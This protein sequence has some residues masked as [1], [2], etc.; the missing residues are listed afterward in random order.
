MSARTSAER[1]STVLGRQLGDELRRLREAAGLSTTDAADVLDCTKGKVSRMEN[2]K[3][4]VRSPDVTALLNAY[5]VH[6][7]K[8]HRKLTNLARAA[9]HRRQHGWW[10]RYG[11]VLADTYRDYVTL[12]AVAESVRTFQAQLV[13]GLL[14]TEKYVRAVTVASRAWQSADEVDQFVSVRMAR[15]KRLTDSPPL[16][17]CAVLSEAVL[18]QRVGGPRVMRE[19]LAA[20]TDASE[21]SNVTVQVLPFSHGAHASMFGPY[22]ILGFRQETAMDVV[23]ADNPTGAVWLEHEPEVRRYGE[24]FDAARTGALSCV[25]SRSLIHR[26]A[27]EHER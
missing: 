2:G 12:E 9:N 7:P 4:L 15:Q 27:K 26:R 19:Q 8:S 13:P 6:E 10:N 25:E 3:V 5:G 17:L 18:L 1:P 20:L 14:Q 16:H 22:L 21:L 23:L 24:L 11:P